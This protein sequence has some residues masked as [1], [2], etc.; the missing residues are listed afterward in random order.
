LFE[1]LEFFLIVDLRLLSH[2]SPQSDEIPRLPLGYSELGKKSVT[3][4]PAISSAG[5]FAGEG[6]WS[7]VGTAEIG[8]GGK[9]CPHAL[10]AS[11]NIGGA[12]A[13]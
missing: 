7:C 9:R 2:P 3:T 5:G 1:N 6:H 10:I 8:A 4:S 12:Q 13:G 11:I